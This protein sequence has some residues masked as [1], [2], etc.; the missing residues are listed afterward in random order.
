MCLVAGAPSVDHHLVGQER[1]SLQSHMEI[2]IYSPIDKPSTAIIPIAVSPVPV[3]FLVEN[4][5]W[6]LNMPG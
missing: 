6:N 5:T 3:P 1:S 2:M 4:S